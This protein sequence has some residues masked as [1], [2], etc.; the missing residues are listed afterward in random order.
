MN[1]P[2][3]EMTDEKLERIITAHREV[4]DESTWPRRYRWK[5]HRE[6]RSMRVRDWKNQQYRRWPWLWSKIR[7]HRERSWQRYRRNHPR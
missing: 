6:R 7:A 4:F 3:V 5:R 1:E 2:A